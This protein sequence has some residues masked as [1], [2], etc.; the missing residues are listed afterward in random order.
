VDNINFEPIGKDFSNR[1]MTMKL[2]QK[3]LCLV[4]KIIYIGKY[5]RNFVMKVAEVFVYSFQPGMHIPC[6]LMRGEE[7]YSLKKVILDS[8]HRPSHFLQIGYHTIH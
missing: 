1:E 7:V 6:C 4:S 5:L 8:Q 3:E 2:E